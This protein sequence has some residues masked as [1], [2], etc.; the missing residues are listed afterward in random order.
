[1]ITLAT[2]F[3]IVCF[4]GSVKSDEYFLHDITIIR[5][6]TAIFATWRH[7]TTPPIETDQLVATVTIELQ[8]SS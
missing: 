4:L 7:Y 5:D 1:M 3:V 8:P 2:F 6:L